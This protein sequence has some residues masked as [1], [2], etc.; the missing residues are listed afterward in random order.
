MSVNPRI[1]DFRIRRF[2]IEMR[3]GPPRKKD[4]TVR[5]DPL[6]FT[7]ER[8]RLQPLSCDKRRFPVGLSRIFQ[9]FVVK[10]SVGCE[11]LSRSPSHDI[12]EFAIFVRSPAFRRSSDA[13]RRSTA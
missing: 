10:P 13:L 5:N 1:L 8:K 7:T 4:W 3:T 2:R 6:R 9:R 12:L 11:R